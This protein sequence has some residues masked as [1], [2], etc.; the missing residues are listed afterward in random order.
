MLEA[1]KDEIQRARQ[2]GNPWSVEFKAKRAASAL[3]QTT[4][5]LTGA[6]A[7]N[8]VNVFED[9]DITVIEY[10]KNFILDGFHP[11]RLQKYRKRLHVKSNWPK[12]MAG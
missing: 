12:A 1:K 9:M 2:G 3:M 7:I 11:V 4:T 6:S 8:N 10:P 5:V